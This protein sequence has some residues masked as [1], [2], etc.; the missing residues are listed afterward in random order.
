MAQSHARNVVEECVNNPQFRTAV[1][2]WGTDK[3]RI[4]L[5][6][7]A[8]RYEVKKLRKNGYFLDY[9]SMRDKETWLVF[10]RLTV[11]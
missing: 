7:G 11:E 2:I 3:N 1:R 6:A 10:G 4:G 9:C 8:S 5:A